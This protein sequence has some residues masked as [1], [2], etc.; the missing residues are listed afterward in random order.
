VKYDP[1]VYAPP[2]SKV[3]VR[4]TD[5]VCAVNRLQC[6]YAERHIY[7]SGGRATRES[8]MQ[9]QAGT[10]RYPRSKNVR[11]ERLKQTDGPTELVMWH[12]EQAPLLLRLPWLPMRR[13]A[14]A[15]PVQRRTQAWR[16]S[17]EEA[18]RSSPFLDKPPSAPPEH[19][20]GKSFR[21]ED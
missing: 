17:A 11:V 3:H 8:L 4:A 15:V 5:S 20:M 1:A 16:P 21:V 14:V 7:F 10:Q 19:L 13:S 12:S 18:I 2:K 6:T 9:I